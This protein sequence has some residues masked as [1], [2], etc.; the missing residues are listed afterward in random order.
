[1][2]RIEVKVTQNCWEYT[3]RAM[4]FLAEENSENPIT[5]LINSEGGSVVDGLAIYDTMKALPCP[6]RTICVGEASS[7]VA[8]ILAGG[9]K[10]NRAILPNAQVMIHDP[11]LTG[12]GGPALTVDA[13][14]QRLMRTRKLVAEI[15]AECTGKSVEEILEKT[16]RDTF[17]T[18]NEAVEFGLVDSVIKTWGGDMYAADR[19]VRIL[20]EGI[21]ASNDTWRTGLNNNTLVIG[22][23]GAGKTRGYVLPNILASEGSVVITD[24]K[25]ELYE[26]LRDQ[27]EQKGFN[28]SCIDFTDP[29]ESTIGYDP[30][31]HIRM[32]NDK[33]REQDVISVAASLCPVDNHYEPFWDYIVRGLMASLIGYAMTALPKKEWNLSSTTLYLGGND[34]TTA[35]WIGERAN[36][37]SYAILSMPVEDALLIQ[38]G[39]SVQKVKRYRLEDH[40][41]YEMHDESVGNERENEGICV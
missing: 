14:S 33:V 21:T 38:R 15:M 24:T 40:Q 20:A 22:P 31:D 34:P 28:V 30:L 10:G 27:L 3:I 32:I 37:A 36:R 19:S 12:C 16:A 1:M 9:E 26:Q 35:R 23:S 39:K 25:G 2:I 6:V 5:L 8:V 41:D 17:F 4:R 29:A 18:A 7:M 11:I 13:I